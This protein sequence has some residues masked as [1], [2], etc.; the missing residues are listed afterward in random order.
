MTDFPSVDEEVL[1]AMGELTNIIIGNVKGIIEQSVGPMALSAPTSIV[2]QN[3][4]AMQWGNTSGRSFLS[5]A[6][7]NG[8]M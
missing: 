1:N 6:G 7:A 4:I 5:D 2:G 3:L 8:W